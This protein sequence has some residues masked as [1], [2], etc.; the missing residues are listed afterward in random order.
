MQEL[1][2]SIKN[3]TWESWALKKEDR[4]RTSKKNT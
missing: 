3:Q 4:W 2:N 1:N